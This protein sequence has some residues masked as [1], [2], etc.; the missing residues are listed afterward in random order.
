MACNCNAKRTL[1][2]FNEV[3]I[4]PAGSRLGLGLV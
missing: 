4:G 3:V 1:V 2:Q